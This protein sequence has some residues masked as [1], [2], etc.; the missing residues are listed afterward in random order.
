MVACERTTC[1]F[2]IESEDVGRVRPQLPTRF[3]TLARGSGQTNE[4]K[5]RPEQALPKQVRLVAVT[6]IGSE[7]DPLTSHHISRGEY[8]TI[9]VTAL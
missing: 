8:F 3:V 4:R 6:K 7:S 2:C 9:H 1:V 5:L